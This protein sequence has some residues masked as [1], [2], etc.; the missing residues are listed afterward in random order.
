[1]RVVGFGTYDL[2]RHPRVGIVL[3]GLRAHGDDV[4]ELNAPLGFT[5]AQRVAMLHRPWLAYRLALRLIARWAVLAR[6]SFAVRRGAPVDVVVVGYLGHFDVLL[7]RLLFP[8]TPIALDLMIFAA[9]TA[10]DRGATG[11][12]KLALLDRLDRVAVRV[13]DLVLLDTEEH[14]ALLPLGA[15]H[16]AVVVPVGAPDAWFAAGAARPPRKDGPLRAAF[17]G[18]YTPLQGAVVLASAL[19]SLGP[20]IEVTMIGAGQDLDAAREAAAGN[21]RVTWHD[22]IDAADLP[23]VVASHDV[24][25]GIFGTTPKA[26][27]VV[28]NKVFQGAAAGC[29]I[30]TSD[31]APQ[32]RALGEAAR[33]V[34]AGDAAALAAA[35]TTLHADR[36]LLAALQERARAVAEA[37]FRGSAIVVPLRAAVAELHRAGDRA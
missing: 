27:R 8:R 28:P 3:D 22:W 33:F 23:G 19:A 21:P 1:M 30:V 35:L 4:V 9:D 7:A 15:A 32:R 31:T 17:F 6:R 14:V 13:S 20:G 25:L 2:T 11:G 26:Q 18:L 29:A 5:T 36:A 24:C 34:P 16:K 37:A 10:R 12:V